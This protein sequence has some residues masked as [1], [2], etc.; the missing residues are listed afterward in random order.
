MDRDEKKGLLIAAAGH[1]GLLALLSLG[2]LTPSRDLPSADDLFAVDLVDISDLPTA[3]RHV[4]ATAPAIGPDEIPE[5]SVAAV[6]DQSEAPIQPADVSPAPTPTPTPA[7]APK[8]EPQPKPKPVES[9]PATKPQP[10]PDAASSKA[11][12]KPTP[13][14]AKP[15][16]AAASKPK[17]PEQGRLGKDWLA[18]VI[19]E[20]KEKPSPAKISGPAAAGLAQAIR[21][22]VQPCWNPPAGG[23]DVARL[24]TILRINFRKDGTVVG[25]PEITSQSG[26]SADNQAYARQHGEA[27]KRA[28]LRCQPLKLPADLYD[29]WKDIEFNFDARLND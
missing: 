28:V 1:I 7:P 11:E 15:A 5:E 25:Q 13:A 4:E 22:Q 29:A 19:G 16:A 17:A 23:A 21:S 8:P 20:G 27:A 24:V 12:T 18:S 9:K 10:K 2:L 26:V 14:P 3:P 6:E